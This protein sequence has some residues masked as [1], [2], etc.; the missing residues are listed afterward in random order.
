[1]LGISLLKHALRMLVHNIPMTLRLTFLPYLLV[2]LLSMGIMS[3]L[4]PGWTQGIADAANLIRTGEFQ[5]K[6]A[7]GLF[8]GFVGYVLILS[9]SAIAWHRYALLAEHPKSFLPPI[10]QTLIWAYLGGALRVFLMT[11]LW[12]LLLVKLLSL[13]SYLFHPRPAIYLVLF[14]IGGILIT[15][16]ILRYSLIL[17]AAALGTPMRLREATAASKGRFPLF[18]FVAFVSWGI[19]TLGEQAAQFLGWPVVLG[20]VVNWISFAL[21]LSLLTTLYGLCVEDRSLDG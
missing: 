1:M 4:L 3:L 9:W 2:V 21:G 15:S 20:L 18:L 19:S 11:F 10:N 7:L 5:L 14:T 16:Q 12:G 6:F 13:L 17:P 8:A